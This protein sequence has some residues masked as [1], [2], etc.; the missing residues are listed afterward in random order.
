[1]GGEMVRLEWITDRARFTG[2]AAPWDALALTQSSPFAAHAWLTAWWDAFA[3]EGDE[4]SVAVLWRGDDLVAGLPLMRRAGR[5]E[6]LANWHTPVFGALGADEELQRAVMA[7]ALFDGARLVLPALERDG[8]TLAAFTAAATAARIKYVVEPHLAAP[9][10]D[11]A[12]GWEDY[13]SATKPRWGAPLERWRRKMGREHDL[14]ARIVEPPRDLASEL[15][16]GFAVEASGWKGRAGTAILSSP[17]TERFYRAVAEAFAERDALRLSSLELDG[18]MV[19]F[20]LCLLH[21]GRLWLLKTGYDE[22]FRRL[23]PGLVLRLW[24]IERCFE[25]GLEAHELLGGDDAW[26]RKFATSE[27]AHVA[28]RAYPGGATAAPAYAFRRYGRPVLKRAYQRLLGT[29]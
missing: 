15:E 10:V 23:G 22:R 25:L 6:A 16:R 26:K 13:R 11:I 9:I 24:V 12:G 1:M 29:G 27:R 19:A 7:S 3:Q 8:G 4:L 20:D 21:A 17:Q 2:I 14:V 28:L 18:E 5:L